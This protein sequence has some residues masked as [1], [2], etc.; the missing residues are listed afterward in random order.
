MVRD[1]VL[2]WL[3]YI[4]KNHEVVA[5]IFASYF[6]ISIIRWWLIKNWILF[7]LRG[8]KED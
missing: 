4:V 5:F 7:L 6:T 3:E 8:G 1:E 2:V